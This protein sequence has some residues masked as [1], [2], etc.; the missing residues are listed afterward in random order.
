ME[1]HKVILLGDA[2]VGKTSICN[3]K[4]RGQ[5]T[6]T[7]PT[8]GVANS[9]VVIELSDQRV[10][11]C[12]WDTAGQEQFQSMTPIYLK[13]A[14][15]CIIVASL[16][17]SASI[18]HVAKWRQEIV[19]SIGEVPIIVAVNKIDIIGNPPASIGDVTAKLEEQFE[20]IFFVSAKN[21]TGIDELFTQA[22]KYCTQCKTSTSKLQKK[23]SG[24]CC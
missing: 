1:S 5:F 23:E 12:I 16:F 21:G 3:R 9:K 13:N 17:D 18:Q 14:D 8:V 19:D 7:A 20:S 24:S 15:V 11:M 2:N 10:E 4:F 6:P 22:A